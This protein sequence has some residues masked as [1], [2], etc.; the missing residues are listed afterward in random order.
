MATPP[1]EQR[2]LDELQRAAGSVLG[3]ALRHP[4]LGAALAFA[5]E[6]GE[7]MKEVMQLEIY[8]D[9]AARDRLAGEAADVLFSLFEV[10]TCYQ[11]PLETHYLAK[12][13][14]LATKREGWTKK[15]G[16]VLNERRKVLDAID[17]MSEVATKG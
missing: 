11:I 17:P 1:P 13:A 5:E 14:Q 6:S 9:T 15:Y 4:R 12:V 10:C 16:E 2:T 7:L 8:G 3:D